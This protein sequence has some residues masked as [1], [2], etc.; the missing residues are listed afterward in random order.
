M[1]DDSVLPI[2]LS[3][4]SLRLNDSLVDPTEDLIAWGHKIEESAKESFPAH[5]LNEPNDILSYY[6]QIL[7]V[8][9]LKLWQNSKTQS[10]FIVNILAMDDILREHDFS[11]LVDF[12]A[13]RSHLNILLR[14]ANEPNLGLM[15]DFW[16][17]IICLAIDEK[18]HLPFELRD[19]IPRLYSLFPVAKMKYFYLVHETW[20]SKT[21]T[22][23]ANYIAL[24]YEVVLN[25]NN[26]DEDSLNEEYLYSAVM[27]NNKSGHSPR[28]L[29]FLVD[30]FINGF[31]NSEFPLSF[32]EGVWSYIIRPA[33]ITDRAHRNVKLMKLVDIFD[34]KM[35]CGD[36]LFVKAW[37][38]I[39]S[40]YYGEAMKIFQQ[41][42]ELNGASYSVYRNL[43]Y[44]AAKLENHKLA[45][46]YELKAH[47]DPHIIV[48][49]DRKDLINSLLEKVKEVEAEEQHVEAI[50]SLYIAEES[51]RLEI[52]QLSLI[53]IIEL[54]ALLEEFTISGTAQCKPLYSSRIHWLP[55]AETSA[56]LAIKMIE[57]EAVYF[58]GSNIGEGIKQTADN[59]FLL[60][61][62]KIAI[63]PNLAPV[64]HWRQQLDLLHSKLKQLKQELCITEIKKQ[65]LPML[66]LDLECYIIERYTAYGISTNFKARYKESAEHCL[67]LHSLNVC[68]GIFY[69]EIED[70]A[71]KQ[72]EEH[73]TDQHT[74]NYGL[75]C[76]R[77]KATRA[78]EKQWKL[79]G[80]DRS[81]QASPQCAVIKT[82]YANG[83]LG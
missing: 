51:A 23:K 48:P 29:P 4:C 34:E 79:S 46:E 30:A 45:Y 37:N 28:P 10:E 14:L 52:S 73:M 7:L 24:L 61:F 6:P 74:V 18:A 83:L 62:E 82:I 57:N 16:L 63:A 69:H 20:F 70:A 59:S 11:G 41:I 39:S 58:T 40:E 54:I 64:G 71:A 55:S 31:E 66:L 15:R 49:E 13:E 72:R 26:G 47:N 60:D 67:E 68:Y 21:K 75:S 36:P 76:A 5:I 35:P 32:L 65:L 27:P 53:E 50:S 22:D 2:T 3:L 44:C 9:L 81:R 17:L 8:R 33:A 38:L 12:Y 56:N 80:Y 78:K 43:S 1:L 42:L 25:D 77:N 19:E